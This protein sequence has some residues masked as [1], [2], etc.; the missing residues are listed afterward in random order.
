VSNTRSPRILSQEDD[1]DEEA[2]GVSEDQVSRGPATPPATTPGRRRNMQAIRRTETK[3]EVAL[4]STLHRRG[5]RFRKDLRLDLPDGRV[6]PDIVFPA[7][8]VAV[9]VDGCFW[10]AC[11]KH[12][13][14]PTRNI[15]YWTPKL[16]RTVERDRRNTAA[17]EAAGWT[18]L[19][20]WEHESTE[21]AA[22]RIEA[23]V[24]HARTLA[25][26]PASAARNDKS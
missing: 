2:S 16:E 23:T 6:R 12:G 22:P 21:T 15:N 20:I 19:R 24:R 4:R 1:D 9:F 3:P 14:H 11:P 25:E 10:H 18:V 26:P 17:L 7:V 5:L 8:K 13:R